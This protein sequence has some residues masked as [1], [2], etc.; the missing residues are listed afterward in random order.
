MFSVTDRRPALA[1]ADLLAM[2]SG[3]RLA[4]VKPLADDKVKWLFHPLHFPGVGI[5]L[6]VGFRFGQKSLVNANA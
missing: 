4:A 5:N 2:H 3:E 1:D 6:L